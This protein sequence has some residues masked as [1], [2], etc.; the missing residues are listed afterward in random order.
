MHLDMYT[1]VGHLAEPDITF[2][3]KIP[4]L[5]GKLNQILGILVA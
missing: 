4:I 3:F 1:L 2:L 5:A